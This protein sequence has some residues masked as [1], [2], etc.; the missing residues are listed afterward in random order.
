MLLKQAAVLP[1]GWTPS[2]AG[3]LCCGAWQLRWP[4]TAGVHAQHPLGSGIEHCSDALALLF[5]DLPVHYGAL[6]HIRLVGA[7]A[8]ALCA[9][10]A[11]NVQDRDFGMACF[12]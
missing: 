7:Q 4:C 11:C 6:S 1:G 10:T 12:A 2:P 9:Y 5:W 3:S 8:T